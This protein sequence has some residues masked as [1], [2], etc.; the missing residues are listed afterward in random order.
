MLEGRRKEQAPAV[1]TS[2]NDACNFKYKA[3]SFLSSPA[4][5][6]GEALAQQAGRRPTKKPGVAEAEFG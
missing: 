6:A 1:A 2:T 3:Q 4:I 5:A